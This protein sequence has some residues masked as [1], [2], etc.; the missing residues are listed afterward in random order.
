MDR[1]VVPRAGRLEDGKHQ[2]R[3]PHVLSLRHQLAQVAEVVT[4]P[5]VPVII[6]AVYTK[7]TT[8][9]ALLLS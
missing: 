3:L 7:Q 4:K 9:I 2:T 8:Q 5:R 6:V 1:V